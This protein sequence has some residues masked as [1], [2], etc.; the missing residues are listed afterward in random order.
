MYQFLKKRIHVHRNCV[1]IESGNL[2]LAQEGFF[3][4]LVSQNGPHWPP[5]VVRLRFVVRV[6]SLVLEFCTRNGIGLI[7]FVWTER[8]GGW[9]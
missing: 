3:A 4:Y 9:S 1:C 2:F 7:F 8:L 6:I 5:V